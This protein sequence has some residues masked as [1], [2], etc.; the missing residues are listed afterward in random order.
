MTVKVIKCSPE[1]WKNFS[2]DAHKAVFDE[3]RHNDLDRIDYAIIAHNYERPIGFTTCR[4]TDSE[5][6]YWQ[7]GGCF[8]CD[9]GYMAVKAFEALFNFSKENYKRIST[10]VKNDNVN[11]LHMLM[12]FGFRAIGLRNFKGDIFLE[13]FWEG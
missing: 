3:V 4:E 7:Y 1:E 9:R 6:L 5:S 13:M 10:L 11:Y 8:E 12:K 2:Q